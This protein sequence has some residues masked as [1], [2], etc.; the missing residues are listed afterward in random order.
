MGEVAILTEVVIQDTEMLVDL[1]QPKGN[2]VESKLED[3]L[4]QG[5]M[6]NRRFGV[7]VKFSG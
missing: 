4:L 2:K 3:Q 5:Q 6:T 1:T 7:F